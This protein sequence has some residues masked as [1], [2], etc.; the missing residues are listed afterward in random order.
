MNDGF[1]T[2]GG[3]GAMSGPWYGDPET[4]LDLAVGLAKGDG[5][6]LPDKKELRSRSFIGTDHYWIQND[7]ERCLYKIPVKRI[8]AIIGESNRLKADEKTEKVEAK[9]DGKR[10]SV[11]SAQA[12]S[13]LQIKTQKFCVADELEG[14][15]KDKKIRALNY[16]L[17]L[18]K[19]INC[20]LIDDDF[21]VFRSRG[22]AES[23]EGQARLINPDKIRS[24]DSES[25]AGFVDKNFVSE[26][27]I[28]E[29]IFFFT[30][31]S[32]AMEAS[33]KLLEILRLLEIIK[34]DDGRDY[35]GLSS[36][37]NC[38]EEVQDFKRRALK[39]MDVYSSLFPFCLTSR[40]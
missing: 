35:L 19:E 11:F 2:K 17:S 8:K 39:W 12:S 13:V 30:E 5:I 18:N 38:I 4:L 26:L 7:K 31:E 21:W 14:L 25:I 34:T 36:L 23:E 33:Q 15:E 29:Q 32:K 9:K 20:S 16:I 24:M 10:Q 37:R 40:E 6:A 1:T 27:W 3:Q 22:E 28:K